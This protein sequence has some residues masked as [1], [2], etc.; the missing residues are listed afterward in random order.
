M[1][2]TNPKRNFNDYVLS[3]DDV[4]EAMRRYLQT[5][6]YTLKFQELEGLFSHMP[7]KDRQRAILLH[8]RLCRTILE[9]ISH[10]ATLDELL[11]EHPEPE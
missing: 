1:T 7:H 8:A 4:D 11:E 10:A 6:H 5:N 2:D 9:A 3:I